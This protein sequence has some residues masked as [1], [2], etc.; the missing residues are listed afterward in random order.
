LL[1]VGYQAEGT[2]GRRI[3]DGETPI[4]LFGEQ[5]PVLCHV[6]KLDGLSA[7]ADQTELLRWL[8]NFSK[9]PKRTFIVHGEKE[10]SQAFARII[11]QQLGWQPIVPEYLESVQLF[12]GI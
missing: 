8:A 11:E 5:V 12:E 9:A 4:K 7:H 1:L 2:R 10:S 3:Q 6:E